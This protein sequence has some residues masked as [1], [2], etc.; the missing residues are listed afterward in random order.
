M[1]CCKPSYD[2][3]CYTVQQARSVHR[4]SD[5]AGSGGVCDS[6]CEHMCKHEMNTCGS[7]NIIC[8]E[9]PTLLMKLNIKQA[10]HVQRSRDIQTSFEDVIAIRDTRTTCSL[11]HAQPIVFITR[12]WLA[13]VG[14]YLGTYKIR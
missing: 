2:M 12:S 11:P 6:H 9:A 5:S 14:R 1:H 10:G 13:I 3:I 4:S 8:G 7:M